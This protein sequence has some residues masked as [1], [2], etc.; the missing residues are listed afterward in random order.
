MSVATPSRT[1]KRLAEERSRFRFLYD[2]RNLLAALSR[3]RVALFGL[4]IMFTVA[5][6]AVFAPLI[7]PHDP[8]SVDI[9][10]RLKPPVWEAQGTPQ[11]L[12][13]PTSWGV[14]FSAA[15][16]LEAACRSP[17]DWGLSQRQARSA[18]SSVWSLDF[19][20]AALTTS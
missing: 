9:M 18:F 11:Y 1:Q 3:D 12:L 19:T 4:L 15:S 6:M 10:Q 17:S 20:G 2:L 8:T 16:Y 14:T 5:V 7:A 13:G